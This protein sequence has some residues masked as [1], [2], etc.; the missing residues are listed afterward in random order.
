MGQCV[1]W[2][3]KKERIRLGGSLKTQRVFKIKKQKEGL[4]WEFPKQHD[5]A[6]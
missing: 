1:P 2:A 6:A 5:Y 4:K 3:Q